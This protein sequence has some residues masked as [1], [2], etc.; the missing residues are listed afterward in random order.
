[1]RLDFV[2]MHGCGNDYIY[3]DCRQSSPPEDI[4]GLS[5]T[6]SRRHFAVGAD[7]V[8]CICAPTRPGADAAMRM[9]NADGSEGRMCGNGIRCVAE[10]LYGH[11]AARP[12][13]AVDTAAGR[14]TLRRQGPGLWQV[15]M[16]RFSAR[17]A[18][19]PAVGLGKG[20]L[21]RVP[22]TVHGAR[23]EVSALSMGNPHCVVLWPG[24]G[25][26]PGGTALAALG[27]GFE[28]HPAFPAGANAEFV[29]VHGAAAL[30]M[31]VWERGSGATLACGTGACA[32]AA[33]MV[34]RGLCRRGAP[35]A[36]TVP[37]G[38]LTVQVQPDDTVLLTGPAET[39]FAG[40][41]TV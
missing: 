29:T 14:K 37:G 26:L 11:G 18:D 6:L 17:A 7:G 31:T 24:P 9:Y 15:E 10:Y 30:E 34:L 2:K 33:A 40:S 3:L 4:A 35:I 12:V 19:V 16:G 5:R 25:P 8:I 13:L 21:L 39:A 36:V 22:L 23:Y 27:P 38:T 32:A 28:K 20:P 41:V 1:M